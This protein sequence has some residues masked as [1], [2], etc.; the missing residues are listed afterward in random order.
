MQLTARYDQGTPLWLLRSRGEPGD[1]K[2][3]RDAPTVSA[4]V[5][6]FRTLELPGPS[7]DIRHE[8]HSTNYLAIDLG[9]RMG[10]RCNGAADKLVLAVP[11]KSSAAGGNHGIR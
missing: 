9:A 2:V 8:R 1:A 3:L 6:G 10:L 7:A 5:G 11:R 4:L